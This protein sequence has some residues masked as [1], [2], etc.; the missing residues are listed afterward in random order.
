MSILGQFPSKSEELPEGVAGYLYYSG[1]DEKLPLTKVEK[2]PDEIEVINT[3]TSSGSIIYMSIKGDNECIEYLTSNGYLY[4]RNT[5]DGSD[6][7]LI[8]I[9]QPITL[10]NW[11]YE[12]FATGKTVWLHYTTFGNNVTYYRV[13]S[14][15]HDSDIVS[16]SHIYGDYVYSVD[17]TGVIK[18]YIIDYESS[19][20]YLNNLKWTTTLEGCTGIYGSYDGR[21]LVIVGTVV[22][23]LSPLTGKVLAEYDTGRNIHFKNNG[24]VCYS[25]DGHKLSFSTELTESEKDAD[26][27]TIE[28]TGTITLS[29]DEEYDLNSNIVHEYGEPNGPYGYTYVRTYTNGDLVF[30]SD[31]ECTKPIF[32]H[33]TQNCKITNIDFLG[34]SPLRDIAISYENGVIER[35]RRHFNRVKIYF[36]W[37]ET[38]LDMSGSTEELPG[39]STQRVYSVNGNVIDI[40]EG[41]KLR[42]TFNGVD[43]EVTVLDTSAGSTSNENYG[44][45]SESGEFEDYPFM[46]MCGYGTDAT[47]SDGLT[48]FTPADVTDFSLKIVRTHR[49]ENGHLVY[50]GS[51]AAN[52]ETAY[53][54][55]ET[56]YRLDADELVIDNDYKAIRPGDVYDI[57]FNGVTYTDVV[58]KA[59]T[60]TANTFLGAINSL[61]TGE[62]GDVYADYSFDKYPFAIIGY[63]KDDTSYSLHMFVQTAGECDIKIVRKK[64]V[65]SAVVDSDFVLYRVI[66]AD[67]FGDDTASPYYITSDT[68]STPKLEYGDIVEV[69]YDGT[70]Y[71]QTVDGYITDHGADMSGGVGLA[72]ALLLGAYVDRYASGIYYTDSGDSNFTNYPFGL[73]EKHN[74]EKGEVCYTLTFSES[75]DHTIKI[76]KTGKDTT[77]IANT[78]GKF[79]CNVSGKVRYNDAVIARYYAFN[80]P[81]DTNLLNMDVSDG[82]VVNVTINGVEYPNLTI[83]KMNIESS[84]Y[85]YYSLGAPITVDDSSVISAFDWTD[86][87][88]AVRYSVP[89]STATPIIHWY[90]EEACDS[91]MSIMKAET[92]IEGELI[93]EGTQNAVNPYGEDDYG[94][95]VGY[96]SGLALRLYDELEEIYLSDGDE[97]SVVV[98]GVLYE[99]VPVRSI[100]DTASVAGS[101]VLDDNKNLIN[102]DWETYPFAILTSHDIT[103]NRSTILAIFPEQKTYD[104]KVYHTKVRSQGELIFERSVDSSEIDTTDDGNVVSSEEA[105]SPALLS[106]GDIVRVAFNGES[107][108]STVDTYAMGSGSTMSIVGHGSKE[109]MT[110]DLTPFIDISTMTFDDY[111]FLFGE[112]DNGSG[113][114]TYSINTADNSAYDI[115]IYKVGEDS[116]MKENTIVKFLALIEEDA[117]SNGITLNRGNCFFKNT[118]GI[119]AGQV[120][121]V[122]FNGTKY[123]G[124]TVTELSRDSYGSVLGIGATHTI[125]DNNA[126]IIESIDFSTYP[127]AIEFIMLT[128][129]SAGSIITESPM[130]GAVVT[131]LKS[132]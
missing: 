9:G 8:S 118:I 90:A 89:K 20:Y 62:D 22:K 37:D 105:Y 33:N 12:C 76:V 86:Y 36:D 45:G 6:S 128:S 116:Y 123:E 120:V 102:I 68:Y 72:Q 92:N 46:C 61:Y 50:E 99:N 71:T 21:A 87:K 28:Y 106:N 129:S 42:V 77:L 5:W 127:F 74:V 119:T 73:H 91:T 31:Y 30:Y 82:M 121:D 14:Y 126:S 53:F 65:T 60:L 54:F 131:I 48:I 10:H 97:I 40:Y 85:E 111:P 11:G 1:S 107:Y 41:D 69:T 98:D 81:N 66:S 56:T 132:E 24:Y 19:K 13:G 113:E 49:S 32:T 38:L 95:V 104:I 3:I 25:D 2:I 23:L 34:S 64:R 101:P 114:C 29:A 110:G 109:I 122:V 93:Y 115:K 84:D 78:V 43:Y 130:T 94:T 15:S 47:I 112:S 124:L 16:L 70:T 35:L 59:G 52:T 96:T 57:T 125:N 75:G 80:D 67:E 117:Q 17:S 44:F 83:N 58:A 27:N 4:N 51:V 88:F 79:Y 103:H 26:G 55:N 100:T 39:N 63:L 18:C 7:T 108:T